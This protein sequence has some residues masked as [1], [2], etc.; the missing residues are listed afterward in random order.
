[1]EIPTYPQ[2]FHKPGVYLALLDDFQVLYIKTKQ[3][4]SPIDWEPAYVTLDEPMDPVLSKIDIESRGFSMIEET[5]FRKVYDRLDLFMDACKN[6][7]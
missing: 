5:E 4:D 7:N 3:Q 6:P 1:M 2:F